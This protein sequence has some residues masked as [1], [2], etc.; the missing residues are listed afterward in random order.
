MSTDKRL[1]RLHVFPADHGDCL[2]IEHGTEKNKH[3]V[4]VDAGTDRTGK[5]LIK[6]I[7]EE[8]AGK[9]HFDLFV[10]T[11]IDADHIGGALPLLGAAD[12]RLSFGDVWFNGYVHLKPDAVDAMGGVQ[13]EKLTTLLLRKKLSWN[14]AFKNKAVRL[15]PAG[16]TQQTKLKTG[17]SVTVISSNQD[18]LV[19]LEK[20]WKEDC[21]KAGLDPKRR[22]PAQTAPEGFERMGIPDVT[23]LAE[24]KFIEDTAAP[25]GSSIGLVFEFDGRRIVLLGDA[26]PSVVLSGIDAVQPKGRFKADVVKVAHHGSQGNTSKELIQRFEAESWVFSTSGAIFKHPDDE[27][28]ARTIKFAS[29]PRLYFNYRSEHNDCWTNEA[30]QKRHHYVVEYGDGKQRQTVVLI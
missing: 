16:K 20:S 6:H 10:I 26:Y 27:A 17:A 3:H 15:T 22:K 8:H 23:T 13:G 28:V 12:V 9:V 21:R 14:G 5:R 25:N 29:E 2:W 30:L 11:H 4:L 18:Q 7:K 19:R 1:F 24:S